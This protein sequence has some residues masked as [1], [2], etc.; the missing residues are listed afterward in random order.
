[1]T[2]PLFGC[3]VLSL[4]PLQTRR[5]VSHAHNSLANVFAS[6]FALCGLQDIS[7]PSQSQQSISCGAGFR[8]WLIMDPTANQNASF[9]LI[10]RASIRFACA[11][12][13]NLHS[14]SWTSF[15]KKANYWEMINVLILK[16]LHV[17]ARCVH[18]YHVVLL[19]PREVPMK[20]AKEFAESI[21]AIFIETSAR[22]AVNVEELFQ[23]ISRFHF[24]NSV[25]CEHILFWKLKRRGICIDR[26]KPTEVNEWRIFTVYFYK[27]EISKVTELKT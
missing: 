15:R 10:S 7:H 14:S 23:K 2:G 25:L 27:N 6:Q 24:F 26:E 20:E 8:R 4:C 17:F 1:M 18:S 12:L 22:N 5:L 9:P 13:T 21:A 3:L 16:W 19:S 11:G